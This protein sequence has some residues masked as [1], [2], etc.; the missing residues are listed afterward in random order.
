MLNWIIDISLRFRWL[1]ILAFVV[2]GFV[3]AYALTLIDIDAF[4]DTT[5]SGRSRPRSNRRWP[6]CPG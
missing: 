4:P 1:V 6:I 5:P 2:A 3:G